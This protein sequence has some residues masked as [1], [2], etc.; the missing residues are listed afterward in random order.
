MKDVCI[1]EKPRPRSMTGEDIAKELGITR[2]A[3]SQSLKRALKKIYNLLKKN[4]RHYDSFEIAV[5]IS[6]ILQVSIDSDSEMKKFF[7]LFP[8]KIKKEI[9][10]DA[11]NHVNYCSQ[12]PFD[13]TMC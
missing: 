4:N 9:K 13:K 10:K 5:T 11:K 3:V 12:C 2:M 1:L 7:N 6:Q 8:D